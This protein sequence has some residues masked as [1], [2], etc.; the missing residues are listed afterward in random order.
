M[1]YNVNYFIIKATIQLIS[2]KG[3][4]ME[5]ST[6]T[7]EDSL[8]LIR[9]T[10][11]E[12]R[13]RFRQNGHLFILWGTLML[14]VLTSQL[15]L[16]LLEY[17]SLTVYPNYLYPLGGIYTFIYVWKEEKKRNR[18]KTILGNILGALGGAVGLNLGIMGFFFADALGEALAPVF[19]ILLALWIIVSGVSIK[20]K[21]LVTGGILL[22]LIGLGCFLISRDYHGFGMML[23]AIVG[24]IIPGILLNNARR[25]EHV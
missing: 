12:T 7:A 3:K 17:Y 11:E 25:K 23:G 14:I 5:K 19:I 24:L 15:I 20:F 8:I 2:Q 4:P 16:S 21:P 6:L 18:P 9:K 10:I 22:N 1:V 13:E